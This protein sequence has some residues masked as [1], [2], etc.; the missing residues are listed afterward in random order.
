MAKLTFTGSCLCLVPGPQSERS[1]PHLHWWHLNENHIMLSHLLTGSFGS[2]ALTTACQPPPSPFNYLR[3]FPSSYNL[4]SVLF[5]GFN[6]TQEWPSESRRALSCPELQPPDRGWVWTQWMIYWRLLTARQ[7]FFHTWGPQTSCSNLAFAHFIK[8][9]RPAAVE[10][11]MSL[12][13]NMDLI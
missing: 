3:P 2:R 5:L 12:L 4:I 8:S 11:F 6:C 10:A 1:P 9:C 7:F 13:L